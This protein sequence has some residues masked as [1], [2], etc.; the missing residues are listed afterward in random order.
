MRQKK[1]FVMREV[2]GE[3]VL[4]GEGVETVDFNRIVRF[5]GTASFLWQKA[6]EQ[7]DFTAESLA[8]A[9]SAEY[10]IDHDTAVRDTEKLLA[11]WQ[12][13]GLLL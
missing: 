11:G 12:K 3:N 5:N 13:E 8:D 7:G 6:A 9:L 2:C 1:G 4:I 10:Q